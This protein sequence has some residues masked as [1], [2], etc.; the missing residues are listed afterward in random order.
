MSS[1]S[2]IDT[3]QIYLKRVIGGITLEPA[4]FLQTFSWGLSMVIG[5]NLLIDKCCRDLGYE[6]EICS[7]INHFK[8][9]NNKVQQRAN[10]VNMY[11]S[12]LSA[13][14]SIFLALFL[15]P[16][17]DKN[18]R[19]PVMVVASFGYFVA[20]L[21]WILNAHFK[22]APAMYLLFTAVG[23]L[24]G[25]FVCLLIGVF[26][27]ISDITSV[28]T[29]TSRVALLDFCFFGGVPVGTFASAYV[30][31]YFG[32]LGIFG[33]V[34]VCNLLSCLYIIFFIP[35][36]VTNQD[37]G[38][39]TR[40][41]MSVINIEHAK[42]VFSTTFRPRPNCLRRV[43]LL[44]ILCMLFN[45]TVFSDGN[46]FYLYTRKEFYWTEQQY[47]KFQT[48]VICFTAAA[49]VIIM[50]LLSIVLK[51]HDAM[52]AIL[53][54]MSKISSLVVIALATN[55]YILF[56]GASLGCISSLS[57]IVIRSMLSKLVPP[58]ELGKVYSL[59]ASLEASVPLF[60]T[61]LF[62]YVYNSTIESLPGA[63]FLVLAAIFAVSLSVFT[64]IFYLLTRTGQDFSE[65][66][67]EESNDANEE[68]EEENRRIEHPQPDS[69]QT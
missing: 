26:S 8:L 44:L 4:L 69:T 40:N 21:A 43:I 1:Y 53:A 3:V 32:Y 38:P 35:E 11:I 2:R 16:W 34:A 12:I 56:F 37:G 19:K 58:Y 17:S 54:T 57:G 29:R 65:L 60:A 45:I 31:K 5:Q 55:G 7:D 6:D 64:Y 20:Q 50:P 62:T 13:L 41:Y 68:E 15:G 47:T 33:T 25:G 22:T 10:I 63:V 67:G 23:G 9:Q 52:I 48:L 27:Y 28:R 36:T 42:Q 66:V 30:F 61:P 39:I 49:S 51:V 46:I 18:G 14:P 24:F 59:L